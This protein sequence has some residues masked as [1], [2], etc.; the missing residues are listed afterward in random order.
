MEKEHGSSEVVRGLVA[1]WRELAGWTNDSGFRLLYKGHADELEAALAEKPAERGVCDALR[2][3]VEAW[4]K[5]ADEWDAED[6]DKFDGPKVLYLSSVRVSVL[7]QVVKA[8]RHLPIY[9]ER[10][11]PKM[12]AD[13]FKKRAE[14]ENGQIVSVCNLPTLN[15]QGTEFVKR[16]DVLAALSAAPP[17]LQAGVERARKHILNFYRAAYIKNN[18]VYTRDLNALVNN[19]A[20]DFV[21]VE[22]A[23]FEKARGIVESFS[24]KMD[25]DAP[26]SQSVEAILEA[27]VHA[28]ADSPVSGG[29]QGE[30]E[31]R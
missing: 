29:G 11:L 3:Q 19:L 4:H 14:E 26:G 7:R 17:V 18:D 6:R 24:G 12:S 10:E 20:A 23:V 31:K 15:L 13:V 25:M 21:A 16:D 28:L 8:L 1:K 30:K 9:A 27:I 2:Q 22:R 5:L